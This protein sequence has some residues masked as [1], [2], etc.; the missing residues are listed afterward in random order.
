[1]FYTLV[2]IFTTNMA[3]LLVDV[4]GVSESAANTLGSDLQDRVVNITMD[5]NVFRLYVSFL[6]MCIHIKSV[7]NRRNGLEHA[8]QRTGSLFCISTRFT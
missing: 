2:V 7:E 6:F 8:V 5:S 3:R 4:S 1:M